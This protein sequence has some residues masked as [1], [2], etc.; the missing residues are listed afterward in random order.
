MKKMIALLMTLALLVTAC[1]VIP[2]ASVAEALPMYVYTQNG[3][4]VNV[5]ST[6]EM[7]NNV[8]AQLKYGSKVMVEFI[9]S[10][11]WAVVLYNGRE[12]YIQ[13]RFLVDNPP[14]PKPTPSPKDKEAEEQKTEQEKL[15][16]ELKSEKEIAEPFYII[17]RATR[18]SGWVNFRVGPSKIT[19]RVASFPDAK[20]LIAIGET[21]NWYRARDPETQKIG[22]IHKSYVNNTY[23]KVIE[24]PAASEDGKESLGRL[25]VNG[26]FDLT[27]K[28][29][30]G[31]K[32]QVVNR[33]GSSI[34]ASVLSED[35]T[36]PQLYLSIAYDESYG[37][38]ERMNDL[39][40]EELAVLEESF[41]DMNNVE[42]S[43]RQTGYGTKLL[44][45]KETGGDTDFVDIL[46]I[47]K[48]YFIE[49]NMTPNA[50]AADQT[51][52]DEQIRMCVD[53]LT[54]VDFIPAGA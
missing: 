35:M 10:T 24:A 34:V 6:P 32:L 25:S 51:L 3:K 15:N 30:T 52:T 38:V 8:I 41:K 19:S 17:V 18:T 31:Y 53:F 26:E 39:S 42:I 20:E 16:K 29:P 47:Y 36:K 33:R 27:C 11:G 13:G 43:Y 48:G 9:N 2:A 7:T 5:R 45:A 23:R 54:D 40:D 12:A 49:F 22:Y 44:V 28:L 21:S 46:A 14:A 50:K 37:D 1:A 4:T